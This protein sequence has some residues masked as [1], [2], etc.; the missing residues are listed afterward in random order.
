[1]NHRRAFFSATPAFA[2]LLF[3]AQ[4]H[5]QLASASPQQFKTQIG[6]TRAEVLADLQAWRASGLAAYEV[7]PAMVD[8]GSR[9]HHEARVRFQQ[10][11]QS[12]EFYALVQSIARVTGEALPERLADTGRLPR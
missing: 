3:S 6:T 7:D 2:F 8:F 9:A 12:A 11:R 5:G 1:M 10:L 4:A